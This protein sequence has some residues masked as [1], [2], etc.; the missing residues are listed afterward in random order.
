MTKKERAKAF[1][2]EYEKGLR[3]ALELAKESGICD[4][5]INE[6]L[7][8]WKRKNYCST[9]EAINEHGSIIVHYIKGK[10]KDLHLASIEIEN[11]QQSAAEFCCDYLWAK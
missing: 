10:G 6:I 3:P 5:E 7:V 8:R 9:V 1:L 2:E 4:Y 11:A